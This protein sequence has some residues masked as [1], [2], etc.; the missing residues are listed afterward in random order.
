MHEFFNI[1][2]IDIH[3]CTDVLE[4]MQSLGHDMVAYILQN[5]V[6]FV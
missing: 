4:N 3:L 2:N 6:M 5:H 1:K